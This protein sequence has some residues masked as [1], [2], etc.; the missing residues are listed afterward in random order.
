MLQGYTDAQSAGLLLH[1]QGRSVSARLIFSI[2]LSTAATTAVADEQRAGTELRVEEPVV[3]SPVIVV[4]PRGAL[5][6][7]VADR[8]VSAEDLP[9]YGAGTIGELVSEL[10]AENGENA[11]VVTVNGERVDDYGEVSALPV[12]AVERVDILPRGTGAR[13]GASPRGRVI[14]VVLRRELETVI[15][16]GNY[17]VATDGGFSATSGEVTA[18]R[19]KGPNRLNVVLRVRDE[20]QLLESERGVVQPPRTFPYGPFGTV[21][22]DP[23]SA[24]VEIDPALSAAAGRSVAVAAITPSVGRPSLAA[25]VATAGI[26]DEF[27]PGR[28]RTLRPKNADRGLSVSVVQRLA[29]WLSGSVNARLSYNDSASL[30]GAATGLFRL[31][32][33]H[34]FSPFSRDVGIAAARSTPLVSRRESLTSSVTGGLE[35]TVR[36]WSFSLLTSYNHSDRS[37]LNERQDGVQLA[38]PIVVRATDQSPFDG[39]LGNLVTTRT[40]QTRAVTDVG[41]VQLTASGSPIE[42]PAGSMQVT[43]NG[44]LT[45]TKFTPSHSFGSP[46]MAGD[47]VR[48]ERNS[49]VIVAIPLTSRAGDFLSVVGELNA[50]LELG[51]N[52]IDEAGTFRRYSAG[53][54]WEPTDWLQFSAGIEEARSPAPLESLADPVVVTPGVRY[55]DFLTGQTVDVAETSGGT[56]LLRPQTLTVR[57]LTASATALQ[58]FDLQLTAEYLATRTTNLISTLPPASAAV[59][60]AFPER[61]VRSEDGSLTSVDVRPVNFDLETDEEIRGGLSF[62]IPLISLRG[63]LPTRPTGGPQPRLQFIADHTVVLDNTI[64]IRPGVPT[65]DLLNGGAVGISGGRHRHQSDFSLAFSAPGVGVRLTGV[66]R[67]ESNLDAG[68]G[69]ALGVLQFAPLTTLN[70]NSFAEADRVFPQLRFLKGGRLTLSV[71][72]VTDE[73]QRVT[74]PLGQTPLAYQPAYRDP[75]GRTIEFGF[76]KSF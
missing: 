52:D 5:R 14:N 20:D 43:V 63:L 74:D 64:V 62:N 56:L 59:L 18:T 46:V 38:A 48:R 28:L 73:R 51:I 54:D 1:G 53:V 4:A 30:S 10:A 72:N 45:A 33:D 65:I 13:V 16:D 26:N 50:N 6:G 19:I 7:S 8:T 9:L 37:F 70:L 23:A 75:V 17:R 25:F 71:V 57:R 3:V 39:G 12:E 47:L 67:G 15:A 34:A 21:V 24:A 41:T 55:L 32:A 40:I 22:P 2:V 27:D 61:F 68:E 60:R 76:R 36:D 11:P 42:L 44:G 69:G 29:P 31:P 49:S 35:A 66:R 58:R